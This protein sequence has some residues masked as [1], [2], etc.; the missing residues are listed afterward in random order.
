VDEKYL[1]TPRLTLR[2]FRDDEVVS[3]ILERERLDFQAAG[4]A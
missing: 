4:R 3:S 1:R 2:E